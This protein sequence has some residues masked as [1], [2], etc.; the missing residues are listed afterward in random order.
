[1]ITKR[2]VD[3]VVTL[4]GMS[5]YPNVLKINARVMRIVLQEGIDPDTNSAMVVVQLIEGAGLADKWRHEHRHK[6]DEKV[7]VLK[8]HELVRRIEYLEGLVADL[9]LLAHK[10]WVDRVG[11]C[12]VCKTEGL[13][14][15]DCLYIKTGAGNVDTK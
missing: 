10:L 7:G 1:M 12:P 3:D 4:L 5:D 2:F 9:R 15:R 11:R 6:T 8:Y 13:H 14:T